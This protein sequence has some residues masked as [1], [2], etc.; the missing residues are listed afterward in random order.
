MNIRARGPGFTPQR[1]L[2]LGQVSRQDSTSERHNVTLFLNF[3]LMG[4]CKCDEN[5]FEKWYART[6]KNKVCLMGHNVCT[7]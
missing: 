3:A 4:R 2:L 6:I 1:F 5:N 7:F